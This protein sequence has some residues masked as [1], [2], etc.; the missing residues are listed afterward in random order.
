MAQQPNQVQEAP[1]AV[2]P[3]LRQGAQREELGSRE[4]GQHH[5]WEMMWWE[6]WT[7]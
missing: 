6:G 4:L 2:G 7:L 1:V 3:R 5:L